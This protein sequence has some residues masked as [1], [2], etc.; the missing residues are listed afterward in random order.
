MGAPRGHDSP[1]VTDSA[2]SSHAI[3]WSCP[4]SQGRPGALWVTHTPLLQRRPRDAGDRRMS[5]NGWPA[6][7]CPTNGLWTPW[8][9]WTDATSPPP[10]GDRGG[11]LSA[12][13]QRS[14]SS[15]TG[16]SGVCLA[17][18]R[19]GDPL[20]EAQAHFRQKPSSQTA[21]GSRMA[22]FIQARMPGSGS[23]STRPRRRGIHTG[24]PIC[25]SIGTKTGRCTVGR[26]LPTEFVRAVRGH[27]TVVEVQHVDT[28]PRR[29][30]D[31]GVERA[32]R[33]ILY[34][35]FRIQTMSMI[36]SA[37]CRPVDPA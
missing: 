21:T 20:R 36:V 31:G 8:T 28:G 19:L 3:S 26:D 16:G 23:S 5:A 17:Q 27:R 9:G 34:L 1:V 15:G 37:S 2:S 4:G 29:P 35:E 10:A 24:A 12:G 18:R 6:F 11:A 25:P 13:G 30:V 33:G 22:T 7:V 14:P 32:C